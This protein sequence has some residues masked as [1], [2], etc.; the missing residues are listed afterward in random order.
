MFRIKGDFA[1]V[2]DAV[3]AGHNVVE[4]FALSRKVTFKAQEVLK[5]IEMP[6]RASELSVGDAFVAKRNLFVDDARDFNIFDFAQGFLRDFAFSQLFAGFF[7][8]FGTQETSYVVCAEWR[9]RSA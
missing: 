8:A 7:D 4:L 6:I 5:E 1:D 2:A 9:L 3:G